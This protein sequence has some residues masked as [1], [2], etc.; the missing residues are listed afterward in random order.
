MPVT[1]IKNISS[2]SLPDLLDLPFK[3]MISFLLVDLLDKETFGMLSLA[4]MIFSYH[5][6]TQIGVVDWMMY[7]LPRRFVLKENTEA[8]LEDSYHFSLINQMVLF[9]IIGLCLLL[10]DNNFFITMAILAYM[11]HTIY[12]NAY[13]HKTLF[14]RYRY[15]FDRLLKIRI[16]FSMIRFCLEVFALINFGIY[17]FLMVEAFVFIIPIALLKSDINFDFKLTMALD[18]Y[19][20]LALKGVPFFFVTLLSMI[21]SNMDR[22]YIVTVYGLEWFATYSVGIIMVTAILIIPGKVLSIFTQY[23]KELFVTIH[24]RNLNIIR[25]FSVNNFLLLFLLMVLITIGNTFEYLIL[26]Y[27]PKYKE[28]IPLINVFMISIL[29]KYS[30]SLSSNVLYLL[31]RRGDVS[32]IQVFTVALYLIVLSVIYYQD[33]DILSVLWGISF[34]LLT[35]IIINLL[36]IFII[37]DFGSRLEMLRFLALV[38]IA[39]SYYLSNDFFTFIIP[40]YIYIVMILLTCIYNYKSMLNNLFYVSTKSFEKI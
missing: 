11:M 2:W 31:D 22:W 12:Y 33:Y 32:K 38:L 9:F 25:S 10:F 35:Q 39:F 14:L 24:D 37:K 30:V 4:M 13:M 5:A 16:V 21:L 26:Q 29:L 17:G 6:L 3:M 23:L 1:I 19:K 8:I 18:K 15:K 27:L 34:V 36:L 40:W 28:V 7:E 20:L